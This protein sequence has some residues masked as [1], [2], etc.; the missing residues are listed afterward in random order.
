MPVLS[1]SAD[2][3]TVSVSPD[4]RIL[5]AARA[6]FFE[7][8][9]SAVSTD[10]LSRA[11]GV[12]KA[13]IYKYFGDMAGVLAAVVAQ[14]GEALSV[15]VAPRAE[16]HED[17]W[18]AVVTYG[19]NLLTLLNQD[20]CIQLDRMLHEESRNHSSLVQVF[21]DAA[22]GRGHSEVKALITHGRTLGF[23][24]KSQSDDALADNLCSMWNGLAFTRTRLGLI[25]RPYENPDLW[26]RQCV[27]ALFEV[28]FSG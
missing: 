14:E 10:R 18:R 1:P 28:D 6:L 21:Y 3:L 27:E 22:Y 9:F 19:T 23:I 12:S 11:A 20:F 13:S 24:T 2:D 25:R 8:G 26:S 17:F 4:G 5:Q 15:D 7:H 16:T